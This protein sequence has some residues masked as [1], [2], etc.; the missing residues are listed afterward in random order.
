MPSPTCLEG[1]FTDGRIA[2][3]IPLREIG[4]TVMSGK[5]VVIKNVFAAEA[6]NLV[7]LR[8]AV[9]DWGQ[10][11]APLDQPEPR[12]NCHCLQAGVSKLQKTPHVYHSYNFDRISKLPADLSRQL[13]RYFEPLTV[14]QNSITGNDARLERF[15][16]GPALHPQIL[17]YPQGGGF[18]GRHHH[19][20]TPQKIGLIVGLSRRG[21]DHTKGGTGFD[22]KEAEVNLETVH[23]F[24]DIALFRFD[25][26]HWVNQTDPRDNFNWD[27]E[28]G[29]WTMVLPYY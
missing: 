24:G 3:A 18:F 28:R 4:A 12:T 8:R 5:I 2:A 26:P 19:P 20:L 7:T 21:V 1:S 25:T 27:C 22:V 17:Q 13:L 23:D 15:D 6:D 10:S 11:V 14:F 9:F 29:R 16:N